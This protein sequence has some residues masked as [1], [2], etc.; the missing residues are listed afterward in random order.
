MGYVVRSCGL[1]GVAGCK[2]KGGLNFVDTMIKMAREGKKLRVV[3]DQ[4]VAPTPTDDLAN[5]LGLMAESAFARVT[6]E[7]QAALGRGASGGGM[8]RALVSRQLSAG[9][10]MR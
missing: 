1:F 8:G 4:V 2:L 10:I 7:S 3:D 9:C 6:D 5:Q